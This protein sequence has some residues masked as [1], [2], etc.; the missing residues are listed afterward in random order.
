MMTVRRTPPAAGNGE[1]ATFDRFKDKLLVSLV[2]LAVAAMWF[3]VRT[4]QA[5]V[6]AFHSDLAAVRAEIAEVRTRIT[7]D[8]TASSGQAARFGAQ[9]EEALRRLDGIDKKLETL[10]EPLQRR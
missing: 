6:D 5:Q 8:Q 4:E 1:L 7:A 2:A 10:V 9:G 3:F